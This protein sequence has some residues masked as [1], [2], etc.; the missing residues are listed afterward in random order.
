MSE[1]DQL[2]VLICAVCALMWFSRVLRH[3][4]ESKPW[5]GDAILVSLCVL[6]IWERLQ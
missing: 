3:H 5:L 2:Y 1:A 6:W 4:R